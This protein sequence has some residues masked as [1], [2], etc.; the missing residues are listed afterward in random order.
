MLGEPS[1][2]KSTAAAYIF[3]KLKMNGVCCEYVSEF[4]KDKVY[5][6]NAEVFKHQEYLFGEQSY[7][8]ARVKGKVNVIVTNS[9][10]ILS[11][12]YN[13]NENLTENFENSV[14]EIFNS[15]TNLNYLICRSHSY[16]D[17]GRNQNE[18]E[19]EEVR[20][21]LI[22]V[23]DKYKI[24]YTKIPGTI[25]FYDLIVKGVMSILEAENEQ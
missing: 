6:G 19:A 5:E 2:G 11:V 17:L 14:F 4:A 9:P 15:Y 18:K 23:L 21:K 20:M 24:D 8:M 13:Q 16:E 3:A 22:S 12:V 1:V 10:L 7:K 25:E